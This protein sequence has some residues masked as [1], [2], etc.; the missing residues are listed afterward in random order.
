VTRSA[1]SRPALS[2]IVAV[3]RCRGTLAELH[4]RLAA[5]LPTC[6]ESH[7]IIFVDDGCPDNSWAEIERLAA[8]DPRVRGVKLSRNFGQA[9]AISAGLKECDGER[10]VVMDGDLQDPPEA[11]SI[12]L[13]AA[14]GGAALVYAKRKSDHQSFA[15]LQFGRLYFQFLKLISGRE[16]DP[17]YGT[18][19]L[20][21]RDVIDAYTEFS[22]PRRHYL[23]I[24]YWLGYEGID[25]EYI[26]DRR[27]VGTSSYPFWKLLKHSY[28]GLI[29]Y[30]ES[31]LRVFMLA[32]SA[33]ALV[34]LSVPFG[35]GIV[36]D[37]QFALLGVLL[38]AVLS[39]LG[40]YTSNILDYSKRRPLFTVFKRVGTH[41]REGS[42]D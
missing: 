12:L 24:L 4:G 18:F 31:L 22:E 29:F 3:Y 34:S 40:V 30:S 25:V 20:L 13:Q 19:T 32:T 27:T 26:R 38:A 10:A 15:R 9:I 16:V 35:N 37:I 8:E 36:R 39:I 21:S 14:A 33:M 11:I 28:A 42:A 1:N 2:V 17:G 6:V 41:Y 7:E 5:V 23:F